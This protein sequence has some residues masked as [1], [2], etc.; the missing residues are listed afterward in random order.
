MID[1]VANRRPGPGGDDFEKTIEAR[2][3]RAVA[4]A[5]AALVWEQVWPL[6]APFLALAA[7]F[8]AL[9]WFGLWRITATPVRVA[10]LALFAVAIAAFAWRVLRFA[11][12][13]RAAAFARVEQETGVLHRPATAFSDRLASRS[14]DPTGQALWAAHRRR[15]LASLDRLRA[16]IPSPRLVARDPYAL[17]FLVLLLFVVGFI[18]AGPERIARIGE[19]FRGGESTAAAIARIDAWVTPPAYTGRPPIFL[20]GEAAKP[21]GTD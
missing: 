12:P 16:G 9:S 10:I 2:I 6:I 13:T 20:T 4:R 3:A 14:D 18:M 8:A 11:M 15:T 19:A 21:P 17:R 7:L 5:R 1:S